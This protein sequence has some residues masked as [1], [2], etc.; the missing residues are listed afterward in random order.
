MKF[1]IAFLTILAGIMVNSAMA[2]KVQ[3]RDCSATVNAAIASGVKALRLGFSL[4][5][6]AGLDDAITAGV[7]AFKNSLGC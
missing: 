7:A 4:G 5:A 6:P 3:Q 2:E 1:S